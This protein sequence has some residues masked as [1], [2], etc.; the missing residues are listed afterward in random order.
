M[1]KNGCETGCKIFTGGE[2][3]HHKD[4]QYYAG[5][6]SEMYDNLQSEVKNL[7]LQIVRLSLPT[8]L[9][10]F[11]NAKSMNYK[12]YSDWVKRRLGYEA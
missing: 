1:L 5:S 8:I 3:K 4:C 12:E 6:M 10:L 9:Q 11:K 7:R 2:I